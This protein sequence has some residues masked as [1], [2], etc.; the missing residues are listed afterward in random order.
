MLTDRDLAMENLKWADAWEGKESDLFNIHGPQRAR[1]LATALLAALDERDAERARH[2]AACV[3]LEA[4]R[5]V[6]RDATGSAPAITDPPN[7][8]RLA[9]ATLS[10]IS[11]AETA[12]PSAPAQPEA[13]KPQRCRELGRR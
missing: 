13:P 11:G 8:W 10:A 9:V 7:V 1:K 3:R 6:L 2:E 12:S 4:V 5:G